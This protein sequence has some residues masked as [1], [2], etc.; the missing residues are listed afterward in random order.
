MSAFESLAAYV[1]WLDGEPL[2][3]EDQRERFT[4]YVSHVQSW[5]KRGSPYPPGV[6]IYFFLN[7]Y[8]GWAR[9]HGTPLVWERR[10]GGRNR[11]EIVTEEYRAA[12]GCLDYSTRGDR[13]PLVIVRRVAPAKGWPDRSPGVGELAYGLPDEILECGMSLITAAVHTLS[14]A[15]LWV[16]AEERRPA[17]PLWPEGSGGL[18]ALNRIFERYVESRQPGFRRAELTSGLPTR[19]PYP[20]AADHEWISDAVMHELLLPE[21]QRQQREM[22]E[23]MNRVCDLV[24][25]SRTRTTFQDMW[26]S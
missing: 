6:P 5:Y 8:A 11:S 1:D 14:E 4:D 16:W 7:K 12:F 10:V 26:R 15:N 13:A 19:K 9:E 23:A 2:P 22:I 21:R 17:Q 18:D 20:S 25:R 24:Q 3:T